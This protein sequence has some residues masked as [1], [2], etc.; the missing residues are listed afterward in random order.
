MPITREVLTLE[1]Q[2][3]AVKNLFSRVRALF[4]SGKIPSV[5]HVTIRGPYSRHVPRQASERVDKTLGTNMVLDIVGIGRFDSTKEHVVFLKLNG[6]K[7]RQVWWKPDYPIK[8]HGFN[9]HLTVFR[10]S[11]EEADRVY[12]FL[13]QQDIID[14]NVKRYQL[15]TDVIGQKQKELDL[16]P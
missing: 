9:P 10:G 6:E 12:D 7:L 14:L 8:E 1:I 11:R 16:C 13:C 3:E 15:R 2:D 5:P 4:K